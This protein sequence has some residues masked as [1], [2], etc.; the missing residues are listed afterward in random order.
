MYNL[1]E[2]D[3]IEFKD[4]KPTSLVVIPSGTSVTSHA[5]KVKRACGINPDETGSIGLSHA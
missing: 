4:E 1:C 5:R 2:N 3:F